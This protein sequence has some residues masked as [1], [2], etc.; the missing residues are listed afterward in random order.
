MF[1][2]SIM[3]FY[4]KLKQISANKTVLVGILER[5]LKSKYKMINYLNFIVIC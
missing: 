1:L 2:N 5:K 3:K 4:N